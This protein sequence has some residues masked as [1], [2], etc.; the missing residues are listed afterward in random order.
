L[1]KINNLTV[2]IS[3]ASTFSTRIMWQGQSLSFS[4]VDMSGS[5]ISFRNLTWQ[6]P[7]ASVSKL[8]KLQFNNC[9]VSFNDVSFTGKVLCSASICRELSLTPCQWLLLC[10]RYLGTLCERSV[11]CPE[12]LVRRL[13]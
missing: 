4:L 5:F 2:D 12:Y 11:A 13:G 10:R 8:P 9:T 7:P 3:G 6:G 1:S